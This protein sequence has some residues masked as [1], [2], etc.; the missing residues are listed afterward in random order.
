[1]SN[2]LL[3]AATALAMGIDLPTI[4]RGL[5]AVECIPLRMERV[6]CGQEFGVFLDIADTPDRLASCLKALRQI[7]Q[8]RVICIAN[9][10]LDGSSELRPLIGRVLEK[11]ADI[12]LITTSGGNAP[13]QAVHDVIDGYQRPAKAHA[14]PDREQAIAWAMEQAQP[15]D[16]V[17]IAGCRDGRQTSNGETETLMVRGLLRQETADDIEQLILRIHEA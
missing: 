15:G 2:C 9:A 17:L 11:H 6:E 16:C 14:I 3:V 5:E 10:D 1:M 7:R 12:G 8:G 4:V 13:L